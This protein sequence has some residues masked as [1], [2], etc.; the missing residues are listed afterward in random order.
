MVEYFYTYTALILDQSEK[1]EW[2][3][4]TPEGGIVLFHLL[5][6]VHI[7]AKT[8]TGIGLNQGQNAYW[9]WLESEPKHTDKFEIISQA[10]IL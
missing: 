2:G 9:Y 5:L 4:F 10:S 7:R 3:S 8:L 6:S 1:L